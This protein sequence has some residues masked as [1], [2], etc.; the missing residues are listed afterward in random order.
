MGAG[1]HVAGLVDAMHADPHN[2]VMTEA[3]AT[4]RVAVGIEPEDYDRAHSGLHHSPLMRELWAR[5]MGDEYPSQV[6]P[7]SSCSWWVLGRAVAGLRLRPD[8]VLVDLGCGRGGPGLWLARALSARLVGIDF[9]AAAVELA[10]SRAPGFVAPGRAEFR[11]ATLADTGLPDRYADG[12]VSIDVLPFAPDRRA[13]L[14]E[15]RRILVPG[16]RLVATVRE[17]PAG[18]DGWAVLAAEAGLELESSTVHVGHDDFWTR[19]YALW[20]EH[21]AGL[22]AEVGDAATDNFLREA[23]GSRTSPHRERPPLLL[24]LH[25]TD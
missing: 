23:A 2:G 1:D 18:E 17:R 16:G 14:R 4:G 19:L 8:G 21:E 9:S 6:E 15:V 22:R 24:V 5:A 12:A 11:R 20:E 13:V 7:F 10:A 3:V 25:R